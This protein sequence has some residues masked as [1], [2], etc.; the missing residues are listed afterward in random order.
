MEEDQRRFFLLLSE[1]FPPFPP[2]MI[3][4]PS[5]SHFSGYLISC[6]FFFLELTSSC[7]ISPAEDFQILSDEILE[8]LASP[9]RAT[10]ITSRLLFFSSSSGVTARVSTQGL[11][12]TRKSGPA[13]GIMVVYNPTTG[14]KHGIQPSHGYNGGL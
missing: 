5:L 9:C 10:P 12:I 13:T 2:Q 1:I 3:S 6:Y 11:D 14:V 4:F 7:F 8:I